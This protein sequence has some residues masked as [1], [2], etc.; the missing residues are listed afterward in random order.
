MSVTAM[1]VNAN[2]MLTSF[3]I[4]WMVDVNVTMTCDGDVE[5]GRWLV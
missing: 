3:L 1:M 4:L 2:V 5:I